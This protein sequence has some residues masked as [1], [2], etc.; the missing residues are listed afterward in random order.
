M[1]TE[2]VDAIKFGAFVRRMRLARKLSLRGMARAMPKMSASYLSQIEQA[3]CPLPTE[4]RI[5]DLAQ[6]LD[7]DADD[8]LARAGR[9]STDLVKI[10]CLHPLEFAPLLRNMQ[11][12][13]PKTIALLACEA[14]RLVMLEHSETHT[15]PQEEC[16]ESVD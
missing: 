10:I 8:L 3:G 11:V 7:V 2:N 4:Q 1:T 6:I 9:I 16:N 12:M 15:P 14:Q 5:K 13:S